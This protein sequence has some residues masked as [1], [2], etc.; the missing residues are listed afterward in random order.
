LYKT[1]RIVFPG[2]CKKVFTKILDT[3]EIFVDLRK[4]R[5]TAMQQLTIQEEELMQAIWKTKGGFVRD[6]M[7]HL[8][9]PPPYTTVASTVKNLEKK[10]F[11][12]SR[13]MA[14]SLFY[15]P[16][17]KEADYA[18]THMKDFVQDYFK[19]SYK[20]LVTFFVKDKKIS[21]KDLQEIIKMIEQGKK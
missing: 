3:Y 4:I 2:T 8:Q 14:N 11:L 10:A 5:K 7:E 1:L 21:E 13:K 19:N 20:E 9:D 16:I 15:E 12:K 6:F 17:I 18:R